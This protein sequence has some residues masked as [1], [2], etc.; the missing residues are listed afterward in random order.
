VN[1]FLDIACLTFLCIQNTILS[2]WRWTRFRGQDHQNEEGQRT[3]IE[4]WL[5][6]NGINAKHVRRFIDKKTG[7]N[8][9]PPAFKALQTAIFNGEVQ[10]VVVYKLDRLSRKLRD[11]IGVLCVNAGEEVRRV[12]GRRNC[13]APF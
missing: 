9:N 5:D 4:R 3:A 7:D 12:A 13:A 10:T 6:G 2:L 1:R 11:G 8:T